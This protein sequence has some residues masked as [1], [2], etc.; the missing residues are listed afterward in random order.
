MYNLINTNGKIIATGSLTKIERLQEHLDPFAVKTAIIEDEAREQHASSEYDLPA[1]F[2]Y[3]DGQSVDELEPVYDGFSAFVI[4][5][6]EW[7]DAQQKAYKKLLNGKLT[8]EMKVSA[9]GMKD[10]PIYVHNGRLYKPAFISA[11]QTRTGCITF[12]A[13]N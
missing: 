9:P 13:E 10:Y 7:T 11:S 3:D 6:T 1:G 12:I 4:D 2:H 8:I 5:D